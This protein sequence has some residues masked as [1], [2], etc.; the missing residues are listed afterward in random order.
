MRSFHRSAISLA[1]RNA[2]WIEAV[3]AENVDT[4]IIR[5][6]AFAMERID[7][8]HVAETMARSHRV[9]SVLH[10]R[11]FSG[12]QLESALV[13]FHHQRVLASTDRTIARRQLGEVGLD[14]ELDRPAMATAAVLLHWS[15]THTC[16]NCCHGNRMSL[17]ALADNEPLHRNRTRNN[18]PV[19]AVGEHGSE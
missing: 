4:E 2:R 6:D 10:K 12:Q 5:R 7:S 14:L 17:A 19:V 9:E 13:D 16:L 11:I 1:H 3:K 8:T 18:H 15:S